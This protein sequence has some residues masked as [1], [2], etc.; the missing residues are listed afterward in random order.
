MCQNVQYFIRN[1]TV[2][3]ISPQ[4]NNLCIS[5]VTICYAESNNFH[6]LRVPTRRRLLKQK[7][8]HRVCRT[9]N[10][11][12]YYFGKFGSKIVSSEDPRQ[13]ASVARFVTLLYP[14]LISPVHTAYGAV[15][16]QRTL[17]MLN[18]LCYLPLL[19]IG[20]IALPSVA[21][22]TATSWICAACSSGCERCRSS[23]TYGVVRSVNGV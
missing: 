3:W 11:L 18:L 4:L 9:S 19:S 5:A 13:W 7:T 14:R 16:R 1:T 20:T 23:I 6:R 22:R 21:V 8:F 15:R 17:Q 2:C 10:W 12:N